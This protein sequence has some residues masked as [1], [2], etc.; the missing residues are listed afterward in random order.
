M[1]Y[2]EYVFLVGFDVM[3]LWMYYLCYIVDYYVM[4]SSGFV[5]DGKKEDVFN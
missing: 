2:W 5:I 3:S 1:E 4:N